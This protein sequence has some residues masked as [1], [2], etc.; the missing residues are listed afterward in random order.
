MKIFIQIILLN[1]FYMGVYAHSAQKVADEII[2][3]TEKDQKKVD[4]LNILG[5]NSRLIDP[6]QT[7]SYAEKAL[8]LGKKINYTNG[9]AESYRIK[10]IGKYSLN[11]S[12]VAIENY[13]NALSLFRQVKSDAGL[14]KVYN[15]IGTLYLDLDYDKSAAYFSQSLKLAQKLNMQ[16][17]MAG[18]YLNIGTLYQKRKKYNQSLSYLKKSITLFTKIKKPAG[19]ISSLQSTGVTYFHLNQ[20][21]KA[22]AYLKEAVQKAKENDLNV[23]I[24]ST[25]LTLASIYIAKRQYEDAERTVQDGV[26]LALL[27]KDEKF[28]YDYL[29]TSYELEFRRKNYKQALTYLQQVYKKDSIVYKNYISDKISVLQEQY[30]QREK[31]RTIELAMLARK[32]DRILFWA[33]TIVAALLLVMIFL[34]IRN[35]RKTA[36]SNRELVRLNREVFYQKENLDRINHTL[37]EIIDE[38][39]KDLK[40]KNKKLSDYSSHLS[41]QIRGP[42][43]TLKGLIILQNDQLLDEKECLKLIQNCVDDVD[44]KIMHMNDALHDSARIEFN[45]T[46]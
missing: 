7:I 6:E 1:V 34:L 10:G 18:L 40:I 3:K 9:I 8:T 24:A 16:T 4:Q 39:T 15:N 2:S 5:Y 26:A 41:H 22:E 14:A 37:E 45:S 36:K 30:K 28:Q 25:N 23:V 44:E 20:L 21:D 46:D 17:L 35:N 32:N 38:R 12:E 27:L 33:S 11:Q 29:Y 43:A 42:I 13:L 19:V 31:Q